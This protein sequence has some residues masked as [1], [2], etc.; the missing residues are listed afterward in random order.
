MT[1]VFS[2]LPR[3]AQ[4]TE[5]LAL[6][7]KAMES[8]G[9]QNQWDTSKS[10]ACAVFIGTRT[11][12]GTIH[13]YENGFGS[14]HMELQIRKK[15]M[16]FSQVIPRR[17]HTQLNSTVSHTLKIRKSTVKL[18]SNIKTHCSSPTAKYFNKVF[19]AERYNYQ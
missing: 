5:L 8:V 17:T 9:P 4:K 11:D 18:P 12:I 10:S 16:Y 13:W 1:E 19:E 2:L 14:L 7:E 3:W 6:G 15:I